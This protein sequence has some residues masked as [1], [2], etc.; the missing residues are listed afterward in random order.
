MIA[1]VQQVGIAA[2][3]QEQYDAPQTLL[4]LLP[5]YPFPQ[6]CESAAYCAESAWWNVALTSDDQFRQRVAFALS[7]LLVVSDTKSSYRDIAPYANVLA[8]DAFGNWRTVMQDI[9]LQPAMG[10]YL[11]ML[12]SAKPPTGQIAN[13]NFGRENLQLFNIGLV[14]LNQDGTELTDGLGN[15][16]PAYTEEDVKAF[17]RAFTGWTWANQDGSTPGQFNLVSSLH[18][19]P[20]VP[21]E[22]EHDE[23][24][25]VLLNGAVL[26]A[27][28]TAE[29]DL[30][31]TLDNI[32]AHPNVAPYVS[33][34]LIQHLVAGDPSPAYVARVASVFADD[35][36][37]VRGDMKA[38]LNAI[39]LDPE[40]RAGDVAGPAE[41]G[42]LREPILWL[43]STLRGLG[44]VNPDPAGAYVAL[45]KAMEPMNEEPYASPSV[46]NFFPPSYV[47]PGTDLNEP[48]F[49]LENTGSIG[50]LRTLADNLVNNNISYV[51]AYGGTHTSSFVDLSATSFLGQLAD[52]PAVLVTT[53]GQ[54][55]VHGRMDSDTF[56]AIVSEVSAIHDPAQRVRVATYLVITSAQFKVLH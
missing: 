23:D 44:S 56:D 53:L 20:M 18:G 2:W 7:Q 13:E 41:S 6:S 43:T 46:F 40:A 26:P 45:S 32:F 38:V 17:A 28:Q 39:L 49:G 47:I 10:I 1:H 42:H 33:R 15:P 25:K 50:L 14:L 37:C 30:A 31:G 12:N 27:G 21:V 11:D 36:L 8:K 9:T 19:V 34:A 55:F 16:V 51:S 48:E 4:A 35:G 52:K 5:P 22:S 3:L 24:V 54:M 29:E